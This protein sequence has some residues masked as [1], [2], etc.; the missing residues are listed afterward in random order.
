MARRTLAWLALAL[1]ALAS[2]ARADQHPRL[3]IEVDGGRAELPLV[4]SDLQVAV[5]GGIAE[6]RHTQRFANRWP[7]GLARVTPSACAGC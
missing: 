5:R 2:P 6:V 7:A 1:V 3:E 4:A